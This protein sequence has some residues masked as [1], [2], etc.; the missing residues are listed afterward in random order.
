[1]HL[2]RFCKR[3]FLPPCD[4]REEGRFFRDNYIYL[5]VCLL[6]LWE[7]LYCKRIL[8][9]SEI[10]WAELV[11]VQH[12]AVL[13]SISGTGMFVLYIICVSSV[14]QKYYIYYPWIVLT[15]T[16]PK[17]SPCLSYT[18]TT[19]AWLRCRRPPRCCEIE[20]PSCSPVA[21]VFQVLGKAQT[22]CPFPLFLCRWR[23]SSMNILLEA[24]TNVLKPT[25]IFYKNQRALLFSLY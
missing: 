2:S 25:C 18:Q 11:H 23:V 21:F 13:A 4:E 8:G 24:Y 6:F 9:P 5:S 16:V 7:V 22:V 3:K 1:V 20:N 17:P 19:D 10:R 12:A 14:A 15:N